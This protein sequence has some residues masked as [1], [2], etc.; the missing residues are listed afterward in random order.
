MSKQS[1]Y[2]VIVA[3][4]FI[5]GTTAPYS[6]QGRVL[7][8]EV[9]ASAVAADRRAGDAEAQQDS[10]AGRVLSAPFR[11]LAKLFGGGRKKKTEAAKKDGASPESAAPVEVVA[12]AAPVNKEKKEK[13]GKDKAGRTKQTR[14]VESAETGK[15]QPPEGTRI[16]RPGEGE[17]TPGIF[18]PVIEGT[19]KDPLSQGRALLQHG[20][21]NEAI[22]ELSVAATVGPNLVEANNLLGLAYDR[23]GWHRQAA[24]AYERALSVAPRDPIVLS[25]L[26]YSLYLDNDYRAAL[27]R[28]KQADR[29]IPGTPVVLSNLGVVQATIGKYGDAFKNFTRAGGE[30]D[31]HLKLAQV[32]EDRG[33]ERDAIKHYEA[34]LRIQ[35]DASAILERL[36]ALYQRT[37]RQTDA[38]AAR[39]TLGQPKNPQKTTTGGGGG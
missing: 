13:V 35:P 5:V 31:A 34:A 6:V 39:R 37:G 16:V 15:S 17:A 21:L 36:V 18:I 14:I 9:V 25:N 27:K 38:E 29:L 23:R 33:R 10:A 8:D 3:L 2:S 4:L 11:A 1:T 7:P 30:Y 28:L 20:Y 22:A 19:G 24:E 26:G 12:A 32:L